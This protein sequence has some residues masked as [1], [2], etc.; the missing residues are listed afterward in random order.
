MLRRPAKRV[1]PLFEIARVLV[2][3]DQVVRLIVNVMKIRSGQR[4]G[5]EYVRMNMKAYFLRLWARLR[6][7]FTGESEQLEF[8][9]WTRRTRR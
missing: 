4:F 5:A 8:N 1:L 2:R 7:K 9:L 6:H 3:L